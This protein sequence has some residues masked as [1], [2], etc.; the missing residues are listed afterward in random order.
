MTRVGSLGPH[1]ARAT[2]HPGWPLPL[3]PNWRLLQPAQGWR[4]RHHCCPPLGCARSQ[5]LQGCHCPCRIIAR[6]GAT[7][8]G[9]G[10]LGL[11]VGHL[12]SAMVPCHSLLCAG[13]ATGCGR[14]FPAPSDQ[15]SQAPV[16]MPDRPIYST[17]K[18]TCKKA[19]NAWLVCVPV[20]L[21]PSAKS[22]IFYWIKKQTMKVHCVLASAMETNA[23]H[24]KSKDFIFS[25]TTFQCHMQISCFIP[26]K[27]FWKWKS[28][29][30][31]WVTKNQEKFI[32]V[33][34]KVLSGRNTIC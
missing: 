18:H 17:E 24:V 14:P 22:H 3:S 19:C 12:N 20:L 2:C 10:R 32:L 8:C 29:V 4:G 1:L 33:V 6:D 27:K 28:Q 15:A 13:A 30:Y 16:R 26:S 25:K 5:G 31:G 7:Q 34:N 21:G 23:I 11:L 9:S